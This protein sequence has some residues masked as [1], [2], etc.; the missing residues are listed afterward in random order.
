MQ[1]ESSADST[2]YTSR[3][4]RYVLLLAIVANVAFN[5]A[6]ERLLP[7]SS[8][9]VISDRYATFFTPAHYTFA[10][11]GVIYG[12]F[13]VY[14]ISGL[15]RSQREITLYDKLAYPLT[16]VNVLATVWIL[17][18]RAEQLGWSLALIV[19]ML[20]LGAGMFRAA[21]HEVRQARLSR[22]L[23]VPF[24]LFLG[25]IGVATF[26]NFQS[27]LRFAGYEEHAFVAP[28]G[29]VT[30]MLLATLATAVVVLSTRDVALPAIVA[31]AMVGIAVAQ[32]GF[33]VVANVALFSAALCLLFV[34]YAAQALAKRPRFKSQRRMVASPPEE[35]LVETTSSI[36]PAPHAS[37]QAFPAHRRHLE[38]Y[39]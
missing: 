39:S 8:T 16:L 29:A 11:W 27:Y 9:R 24:G 35:S 22:W 33:D 26:A 18:F 32:R 31:W 23:T 7:G 10:I 36:P 34:G 37:R 2:A 38:S 6:S 25:W 1:I 15:L 19:A 20:C 4:A 3:T 21:H 5:Y 17:L 14:A 13:I 12:A 30:C 28:G